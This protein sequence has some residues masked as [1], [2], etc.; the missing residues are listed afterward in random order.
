MTPS[1][2]IVFGVAAVV[3]IMLLKAEL[4]VLRREILKMKARLDALEARP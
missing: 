3:F 1:E 4:Y 2:M